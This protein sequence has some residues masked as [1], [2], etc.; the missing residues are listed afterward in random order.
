MKYIFLLILCVTPIFSKAQCDFEENKTDEFTKAVIKETKAVWLFTDFGGGQAFSIRQVD[1]TYY[2]KMRVSAVGS[3]SMVV[4]HDAELMLKLSNDSIITLH[5]I[6]VY[7][8]DISN[9]ASNLY[10]KYRAT[11]EQVELLSKYG[12]VKFRYY[13]TDGYVEKDVK[14]KW[15]TRLIEHAKCML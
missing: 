10:A 15:Q 8:A 12:V 13:L 7:G 5:S 6:D 14:A 2:I 1:S 11:K 4:G 3:V 9:N